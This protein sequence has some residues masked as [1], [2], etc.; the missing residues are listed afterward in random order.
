MSESPKVADA[1]A[2]DLGR[3]A[4]LAR[5]ALSPEELE[6]FRPQI[7]QILDAVA[8]ISEVATPDVEPMSHVFELV[9]ITR[10]DAVRP[11]LTPQEALAAAPAQEDDK[12]VVPRILG[13][14]S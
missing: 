12:F 4:E 14:D 13:T 2:I 5:I 11:G 7:A 6:A 10:S 1:K 9:N 8:R 3:L